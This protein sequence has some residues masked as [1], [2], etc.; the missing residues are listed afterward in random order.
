VV[1]REVFGLHGAITTPRLV[2]RA[3]TPAD[4][5]GMTDLLERSREHLEPRMNVVH[6]GE[7]AS[8]SFDR[9]LLATEQGDARGQAWRR[10][11]TLRVGQP[12]GMVHVLD[13]RRGLTFEGDAGWWIAP[14]YQNNGLASEAVLAMVRH[15]LSD[16]PGG[17]GLHRV[18][19]AISA[20]NVASARVAR[21]TG[22]TRVEGATT[23]VH[24]A[25]GPQTHDAW[26]AEL[27]V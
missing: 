22:F 4:R 19:A 21:N 23:V 7:S 5:A 18:T 14:H 20:D 25:S 10:L 15:A 2:I 17:L 13:I 26:V 1:A 6:K 16:M 8:E 9:L 11:V 27:G 24:L 12:V 3:L